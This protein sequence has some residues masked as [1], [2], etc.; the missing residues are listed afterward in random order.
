MIKKSSL[1]T[2]GSGAS[3]K[4]V[5]GQFNLEFDLKTIINNIHSFRDEKD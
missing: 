5:Y 1:S 4:R 2:S 3:T